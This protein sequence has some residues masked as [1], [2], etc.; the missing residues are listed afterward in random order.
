MFKMISSLSECRDSFK[1]PHTISDS[2]KRNDLHTAV[3]YNISTANVIPVIMKY[4]AAV[5]RHAVIQ[6]I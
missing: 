3:I 6:V 2:E 4:W 5:D 1:P